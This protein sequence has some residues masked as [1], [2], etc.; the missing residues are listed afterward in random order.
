MNIII[1]NYYLKPEP[2]ATDRFNIYKTKNTDISKHNTKSKTRTITLAYGCTLERALEV[3]IKDKLSDD[4][5]DVALEEF[6]KEYQKTTNK[7]ENL[8][9]H[10]LK[11][12][13]NE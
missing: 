5:R 12:K 8:I 1:D 9:R 4:N 3:I 10:A 11:S 2:T 13:I 6:I 7:F